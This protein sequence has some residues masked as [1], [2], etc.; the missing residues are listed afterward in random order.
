M[1]CETGEQWSGTWVL[2]CVWAGDLVAVIFKVNTAFILDNQWS[3]KEA[4]HLFIHS[5]I[6]QTLGACQGPGAGTEW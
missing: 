1:V 3:E 2:L 4:I 5:F 6:Q